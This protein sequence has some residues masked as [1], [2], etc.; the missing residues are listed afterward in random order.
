MFGAKEAYE[1]WYAHMGA[2]WL[3]QVGCKCKA[4]LQQ[5]VVQLFG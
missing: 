1:S 4:Y 5:R 3:S 2:V